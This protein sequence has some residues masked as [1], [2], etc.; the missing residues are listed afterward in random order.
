MASE[1]TNTSCLL[2]SIKS[3][4]EAIA[5]SAF[6]I[7]AAHKS[8][9]HMRV[10]ATGVYGDD[11]RR[12]VEMLDMVERAERL[13]RETQ[14]LKEAVAGKV[15]ALS[16]MVPTSAAPATPAPAPPS[17]AGATTP[18]IKATA[19]RR[20]ELLRD[21][22]RLNGF[23]CPLGLIF[24]DMRSREV[25]EIRFPVSLYNALEQHAVPTPVAVHD[26]NDPDAVPTFALVYKYTTHQISGSTDRYDLILVTP[27]GGHRTVTTSSCP[28]WVHCDVPNS[29]VT[30]YS[31]G[32]VEVQRL[33]AKGQIFRIGNDQDVPFDTYQP[34]PDR[35]LVFWKNGKGHMPTSPKIIEY[36]IRVGEGEGGVAG[37]ILPTHRFYTTRFDCLALVS[38]PSSSSVLLA[39]LDDDDRV[40]FL[41]V[42]TMAVVKSVDLSEL[43]PFPLPPKENLITAVRTAVSALSARCFKVWH[44]H[45]SHIAL[46]I[47]T[48]RGIRWGEGGST[49]AA[50]SRVGHIELGEPELV[51]PMWLAFHRDDVYEVRI[52]NGTIDG[53]VLYRAAQ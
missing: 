48:G 42:A 19:A 18:L 13:A 37:C 36:T 28:M 27:N 26:P 30:R 10:Y 14:E 15:A 2:D 17:A 39:I 51:R 45:L 38:E 32:W 23:V 33:G 53:H 35:L 1:V 6:T 44:S 24:I 50:W 5:A 25:A 20:M 46:I 40:H 43:V 22:R 52:D 3:S 7:A 8:L 34:S 31:D 9:A 41:D 12:D 4:T 16:R 29:L 47:S 49:M 11:L 21:A